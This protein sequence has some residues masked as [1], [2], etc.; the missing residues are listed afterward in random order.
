MNTVMWLLLQFVFSLPLAAASTPPQAAETPQT[1][2]SLP[3]SPK[4]L[5]ALAD[6]ELGLLEEDLK[7]LK[8]T[9][10]A[11]V[12]DVVNSCQATFS[13]PGMYDDIRSNWLPQGSEL[14]GRLVQ[15]SA[16][17]NSY[18]MK[19][20]DVFQENSTGYYAC[21][22][23]T[24]GPQACEALRTLYK[25]IAAAKDIDISVNSC[26]S[27][28]DSAL[29]RQ[30]EDMLKQ[31]RLSDS[32]YAAARA[33][34]TPQA[35]AACREWQQEAKRGL[36]PPQVLEPTCA[37]I[38]SHWADPVQQCEKLLAIWEPHKGSRG[39]EEIRR[40][41]LL[42]ATLGLGDPRGCA[43]LQ[44]EDS[45]ECVN[46]LAK[47][48]DA[49]KTGYAPR[50]GVCGTHLA[51]IRDYYCSRYEDPRLKGLAEGNL[52]YL[53]KRVR[54]TRGEVEKVMQGRIRRINE[55]VGLLTTHANTPEGRRSVG[56]PRLKKIQARR[57]Q[58]QKSLAAQFKNPLAAAPPPS[59]KK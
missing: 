33:K 25:G 39:R 18:V 38:G 40:Y 4:E 26:R 51:K 11:T 36:L 35:L 48:K 56:T 32:F 20:M 50:G 41:C 6:E 54:D 46:T 10:E 1:V 43:K 12:K 8:T 47:K 3:A 28:S 15:D 55:I 45:K 24:T 59:K 29:R 19:S 49:Q 23:K 31:W 30:E 21:Q 9:R 42:D 16:A 17:F 7:K 2:L 57:D 5:F 58:V 22:A 52:D 13:L 44:G 34:R 53:N 14:R 37:V 27:I